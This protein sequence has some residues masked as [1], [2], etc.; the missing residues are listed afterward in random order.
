M[1]NDA[2]ERSFCANHPNIETSLRCNRCEK[3]ICSKC[4]VLTPTGYRCKECIGNQ[5]KSF[6]TA[7]TQDFVLSFFLA[8]FLSLIGSVIITVLPWGILVF[9]LAPA[10]GTGI[11]EIIRRVTQK[12]RA[13]RL[14]VGTMIAIVIGALPVLLIRLALLA[15]YTHAAGINGLASGSLPLIWQGVYLFLAASSAYYRLSGITIRY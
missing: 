10:I 3:L 6:E 9:F 12:R 4:A 8:G 11:G 14:F 5:Q 7:Q 1:M 13:K 15:L 2:A